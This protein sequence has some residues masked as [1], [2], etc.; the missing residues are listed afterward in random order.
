MTI[1]TQSSSYGEIVQE[2]QS[3]QAEYKEITTRELENPRRKELYLQLRA[4]ADVVLH[5]IQLTGIEGSQV[6][7]QVEEGVLFME[8]YQ[9]TSQAVQDTIRN[10]IAVLANWNVLVLEDKPFNKGYDNI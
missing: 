3:L 6:G 9:D 7:L 4:I 8:Y 2:V 10:R 1:I 5:K